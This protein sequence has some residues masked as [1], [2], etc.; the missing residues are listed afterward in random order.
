MGKNQ[1]VPRLREKTRLEIC[2]GGVL[3]VFHACVKMKGSKIPL[4]SICKTHKML[5]F[6]VFCWCNSNI[7]AQLFY[8]LAD[9]F[10]SCFGFVVLNGYQ[11]LV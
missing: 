5:I 10:G 3:L 11:L 9:F 1:A 6:W 2:R 4:P 7:I 8:S